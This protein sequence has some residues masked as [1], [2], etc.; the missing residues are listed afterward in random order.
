M[1]SPKTTQYH[2]WLQRGSAIAI[3]AIGYAT[4]AEI[5]RQLASTPQNVTPVWPPDGLA[6]GLV[7]LWGNWVLPGVLLGSFLSNIRAFIDTIAPITIALSILQVLGIA[8]GTTIGTWLGKTLLQY[9]IKKR[10]PL[11]RVT[12]VLKFLVFTGAIGPIV[13]ATSGVTILCL[14]SKVP[15]TAYGTVWF[16]WWISNVSGIFIITP[17]ILSC[18]KLVQ[19]YQAQ[20]PAWYQRLFYPNNHHPVSPTS[21]PKQK[22]HKLGQIAEALLLLFLVFLISKTAFGGG[23]A[24]EYMLIPLLIWSAFRLGQAPATLFTFLITTISILGTVRGLGGFV[25]QDLNQSLILLQLF[26]GVMA[27]TALVLSA[28]IEE[29]KQAE[30]KLRLAFTEVAKANEELENRVEARTLELKEAKLKADTANEAKSEFLANMSHELRTPLNGILGYAQILQRSKNLPDKEHRGVGIIEQCGSHLLT[31]INDILDLSKIE[32]RKLDLSVSEFHF[33]SFLQSVA[34]ICRIRAEQKGIVFIY[35]SDESLAT[36]IRAD[37]KRLRQVLINL[38]GNA[39]KF[40]DSGSVTLLIEHVEVTEKPGFSEKPGFYTLRFSVKDTGVGMTTEQLTKIFLPFEQVGDTKKQSEGTGLGLAISHKIV[41][42]MGS[43]IQVQ[44]EVGQGST[45]WFEVEVAEA[46]E[47]A[48]ASRTPEQGMITGYEGEPRKVLVVDDRW[49]NRSVVVSLLEPL[50]FDVIEANDGQ[51]GWEAA[52]AHSP[53]LIITDLMMPV[54]DGYQLLK[55]IRGSGALKDV[56]TIAS[57]ATV[58]ESNQQE[59]IDAGANVFLPK[60]V[61]ADLLLQTLQQQ[62][63]LE[64]VY[65][66]TEVRSSN[67]VSDANQLLDLVPPATEALQKLHTLL[68]AGDTQGIIEMAEQLSASDATLVPFAQRITQLANSFQLKPL[69]SLIESYLDVG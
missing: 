45:F 54:M 36:G 5:S 18:H 44:S 23:Y 32:A 8:I 34:E 68:S 58:F 30:A 14:A 24:L 50:G 69:R 20:F 26:I 13:N 15:W 25:R 62:L 57:S 63:K 49:E 42:L 35:Q 29:R 7:L 28:T 19:A 11:N 2:L 64:W 48:I 51:A 4:L 39:I 52:I 61:Q 6:V 17:V 3:S 53:D 27:L 67:A 21:L 22:R 37:E 16:T 40:T 38:L 56:V 46:K 31:L 65:E 1:G 55:Q 59:A 41:D 10:Y 9:A 33:P 60:P 66:Q 12:D 47:W 43:Q